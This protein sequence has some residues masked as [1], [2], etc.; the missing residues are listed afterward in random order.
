ML[1]ELIETFVEPTVST[2][3][4]TGFAEGP[5]FKPPLVV[6]DEND[7][8]PHIRVEQMPRF[9]GCEDI[10]GSNA[11]KYKCAEKK[12]LEYIYQYVKYPAM[13]REAGIEGPVV[14]RFVVE[15]DGSISSPQIIRDIGGGCGVEVNRV[16]ASMNSMDNLWTPGK[17]RGIPVRVQFTLPVYFKLK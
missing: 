12:L 5:T 13:A 6:V 16:V 14:V 2:A 3:L 8:L 1:P 9:P 10:S 7:D 15:K 4:D 17:Q 11:E